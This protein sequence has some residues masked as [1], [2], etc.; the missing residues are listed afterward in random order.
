VRPPTPP[1]DGRGRG[2]GQLTPEQLAAI[3]ERHWAALRRRAAADTTRTRGQ[4]LAGQVLLW[5]LTLTLVALC[6]MGVVWAW[7]SWLH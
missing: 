4:Q 7:H 6:A 1:P 5:A 3:N 2:G